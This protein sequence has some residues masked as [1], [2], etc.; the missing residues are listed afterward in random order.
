MSTTSREP[1]WFCHEFFD[2]IS[3]MCSRANLSSPHKCHAE[4]RPLLVPDPVCASCHG[5]FVEKMENAADDPRH[6]AHDV[7]GDHLDGPEGAEHSGMPLEGLFFAL[8]SVMDRGIARNSTP[9]TTGPAVAFEMRGPGGR[10][11]RIGGANILEGANNG[12]PGTRPDSPGSVP[13]MSTFLGPNTQAFGATGGRDISGPLM[14]QYLMA[15]LSQHDL[16]M[17]GGVPENG[18]MGDYVFNQEALDNIITQIMENSN[19]HRPV[20][21]TEEIIQKLPREVL[22]E[23]SATLEQD[24]AVCKEQ[25]KLGSE[26]PDEQIVVTLPCKHPFHEPCI[27]PWLKS[28]G[29]CPVC[30]YALVPQPE[31]HPSPPRNPGTDTGGGGSGNGP[32]SPGP[33]GPNQRDSGS[34]TGRTQEHSGLFHTIFNGLAGLGHHNQNSHNTPSSGNGGGARSPPR[35]NAHAHAQHESQHRRSNSDPT[36]RSRSSPRS[37]SN[38]GQ[39]HSSG[40]PNV[41]GSWSED[42]D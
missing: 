38:G 27:V 9:R 17:F 6:F 24:C 26:D 34:G 8:Q 4:M 25:F 5:S 29:T 2:L 35:S 36:S 41:P 3:T 23:G 37:N 7:G 10:T 15:L 1:L 20:P 30:R 19:S 14:A 12:A 11:V 13:N 28:S 16:G 18:R 39:S 31:Q 32:H 33:T 22:E 42:L 21:A 40:S